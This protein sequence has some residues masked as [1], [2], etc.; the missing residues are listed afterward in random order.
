MKSPFVAVVV[1]RLVPRVWLVNAT[2]APGITPPWPSLTVPA[3]LPVATCAAA[4]APPNSNPA[5]RI[6]NEFLQAPVSIHASLWLQRGCNN[7]LSP[8]QGHCHLVNVCE[9]GDQPGTC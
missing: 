9:N 8:H 5:S 4:V 1:V 6:A 7:T 3:T 2:V